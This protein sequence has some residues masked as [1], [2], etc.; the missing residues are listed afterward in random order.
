MNDMKNS[1]LVLL[2]L[3]TLSLTGCAR[4]PPPLECVVQNEQSTNDET[5]SHNF[6]PGFRITISFNDPDRSSITVGNVFGAKEIFRR[7]PSKF[8]ENGKGPDGQSIE[9]ENVYHYSVIRDAPVKYESWYLINMVS[10]QMYHD[11]KVEDAVSK[12]IYA[13]CTKAEL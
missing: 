8:Y 9:D 3:L 4:V 1:R 11:E 7:T 10:G 12:M 2:I 6:P 13:H 5:V